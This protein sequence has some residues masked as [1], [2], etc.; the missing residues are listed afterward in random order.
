MKKKKKFCKLISRGRQRARKAINDVQSKVNKEYGKFTLIHRTFECAET[1]GA[2]S[3]VEERKK[4]V[5][6]LFKTFETM[7][8]L[9][10]LIIN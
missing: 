2:E 9:R 1:Q 4:Q 5:T 3:L 6:T 8:G 10:S 7:G